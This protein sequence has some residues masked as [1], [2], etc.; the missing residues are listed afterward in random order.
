MYDACVMS[1]GL[2]VGRRQVA[3]AV[4]VAALLVGL[5]LASGVGLPGSGGS[6]SASSGGAPGSPLPTPDIYHRI[7]GTVQST[8]QHLGGDTLQITYTVRDTG[9]IPIAGF[10]IYGDPANL[11]RVRGRPGWQF[12]GNG[13]C[14]QDHPGILIFWST[15]T[16]SGTVI[17]PGGQGTFSFRVNTAGTAASKYALS[18][19]QAAPLYGNVTV[20]QRSSLKP[21]GP[22]GS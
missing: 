13:I 21:S 19:G 16:T 22:C 11:F 12:F 2:R 3:I 7:A 9:K 4:V 1:E 15:T 10:Q 20:P 18:W 14:G 8:V 5:A 6:S 17:P